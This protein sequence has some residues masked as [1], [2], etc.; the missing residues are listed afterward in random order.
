MDSP[1]SYS[2]LEDAFYGSLSTAVECGRID[3][4]RKLLQIAHV[5]VNAKDSY[6]RT[7]LYFAASRENKEIS[8]LLLRDERVLT[9]I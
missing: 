6:R 5:D 1:D 7:A 4:V 8:V 9:T 3:F 2:N